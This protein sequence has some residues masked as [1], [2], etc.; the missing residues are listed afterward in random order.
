MKIAIMFLLISSAQTYAQSKRIVK[1][2]VVYQ[3][4]QKID[5]GQ[6]MIDGDLVSPGDFS[7]TD[8][9][10][11]ASG[12]LFKRKNHNDRLRINIEYVF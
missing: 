8:E 11:K 6:L 4:R 2:K 1:T 12:L 3:K 7:V 9:K 5:L 10:E